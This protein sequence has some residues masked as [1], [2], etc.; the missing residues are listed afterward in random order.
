[1]NKVELMQ[2]LEAIAEKEQADSCQGCAFWERHEW[3]MPCEKC[4]RNCKDYWRKAEEKE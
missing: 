2:I 4:K 1:M 3:E